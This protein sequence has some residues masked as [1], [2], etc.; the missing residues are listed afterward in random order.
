MVSTSV[1]LEGVEIRCVFIVGHCQ[2]LTCQPIASGASQVA[3]VVRNLPA[4]AGDRRDVGLTPGS[5]RSP[6]GGNGN[7]LQY[8]CLEYWNPMDRGACWLQSI[9]LQRVG[10]D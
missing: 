7:P 10:D 2:D 8:S 3:R 9:G 4:N 6:G 1:C 5:G